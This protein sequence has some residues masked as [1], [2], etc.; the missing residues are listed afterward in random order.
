MDPDFPYSNQPQPNQPPQQTF[1]PD[2]PPQT[3]GGLPPQPQQPTN[4]SSDPYGAGDFNTPGG[5][6]KTKK[7]L[8]V[9]AALIGLFVV[10]AIV[11]LA[12]KG[13]NKPSSNQP[14]QTTS[15]D[16]YVKEPKAVDVES[17]NNSISDNI[18][19]L[20]TDADFPEDN[21]SDQN[22]GL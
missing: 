14:Q 4:Q 19:G 5:D 13:G 20:N 21:L 12:F 2:Q 17:V 3:V 10:I 15:G 1:R 6:N 9:I 11:V 22:L 8:I 7:L 16:F 18:S